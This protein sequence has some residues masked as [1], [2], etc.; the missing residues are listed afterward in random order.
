MAANGQ[1]AAPG[2]N[3]VKVPGTN[4]G[5]AKGKNR[6]LIIL[7]ALALLAIF[8]LIVILLVSGLGRQDGAT[9]P[10]RDLHT[11]TLGVYY[12]NGS[13][14]RITDNS[15]ATDPSFGSLIS[16]LSDYGAPRGEYTSGYVCS[17]YAVDL[18]DTA[19]YMGY[20]T[21]VVLIYFKGVVDPHLIVAFNST[22]KGYVYIDA[23]GLTQ[24]E[25]SRGYPARFRIAEVAPGKEYM[26]GYTGPYDGLAEGTGRI[27]DRLVILN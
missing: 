8:S 17:D 11:I 6:M 9:D 18:H 13:A 3:Q 10:A 19:E 15:K 27:V 7:A 4:S 16:F 24:E 21:H 20:K 12:P 5:A 23:T 14:I 2:E 1:S 25:Q 26:L 22:E